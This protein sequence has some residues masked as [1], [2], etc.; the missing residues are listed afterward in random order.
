MEEV[1]L[2]EHE[3]QLRSA[4]VRLAEYRVA[5]WATQNLAVVIHRTGEWSNRSA[6]DY[7]RRAI[8]LL[9]IRLLRAIRA[10][11]SVHAIGWEVEGRSLDRLAAEVRA[12]LVQVS[13][14][15]TDET[16]RLWLERKLTEKTSI[17]SALKAS[18]PE[19]D[20]TVV[21][22]LYAALS[23]DSHADVA[24]VMRSLAE[25]D[26]NT[27]SAVVRWGPQQT[28]AARQSLVVLATFAAEAA[29][30]LA[31]ESG[32]SY[33]ER[34]ALARQLSAVQAALGERSEV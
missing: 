14:D 9:T 30:G 5:D 34:D 19:L 4:F 10:G 1:S 3:A 2:S 15:P 29:T 33:P 17:T 32:D 16:G 20:P 11:M 18:A 23:Q 6:Q 26:E 8:M 31:V 27:L 13:D 28:K 7:R 25:V 24:G 12:R 22:D 21:R